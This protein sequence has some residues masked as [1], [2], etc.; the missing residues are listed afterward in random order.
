MSQPVPRLGVGL[1]YQE[2][3]RPFILDAPDALD[4][5]EVVPDIVWTDLGPGE[6]PR[7]VEGPDAI[8]FL[9][10]VRAER[11]VIPHGIGL[12]IGSA[13]DFNREQIDQLARW[14]EW[15]DFPWHSEHL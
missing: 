12:S 4:F 2:V 1:A 13:H 10:R 14:H 6:E 3:L 9:D 7:Y 11:P 8:A 15:L 5:V